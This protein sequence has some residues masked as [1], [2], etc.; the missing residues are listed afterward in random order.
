MMRAAPIPPLALTAA[1]T[2]PGISEAGPA[3]AHE[4]CERY[5]HRIYRFAAMVARGDVEAEDLAH[6]AL[7]KAIRTSPCTTLRG[8]VSR[9]GSGASWSTPPATPA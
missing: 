8:A 2:V 7:I 3:D 6:D 4:L 1:G 9:L 5:A